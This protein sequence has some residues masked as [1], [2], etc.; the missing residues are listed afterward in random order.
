MLLNTLD[1]K[2]LTVWNWVLNKEGESQLRPPKPS[3]YDRLQFK[4]RNCSAFLDDLPTLPSYYC[5][6]TSSKNHLERSINEV[7]RA[8]QTCATKKERLFL[9]AQRFLDYHE[10]NMAIF[11]PRKDQCDQCVKFEQENLPTEDWEFHRNKKD[12]AQQAKAVDKELAIYENV[13]VTTMDLQAVLLSP[14]SK[15]AA[16]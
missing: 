3:Q 16:L 13:L 4:R 7:R 12:Q 6:Y 1:R 2:E 14:S 15:A 8:M 10:K 9:A 11:A 5:R